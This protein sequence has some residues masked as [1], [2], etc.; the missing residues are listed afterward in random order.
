MLMGATDRG[1]CWL[2]FG[3]EP[4]P[5]CRQLQEAFPKA[6]LRPDDTRLTDW[7]NRVRDH[8]LLPEAALNLPLDI[9]GTAFQARVW[10]ALRQIPLGE[11]RSYSDLARTIGQPT[12]TRAVAAA[13]AANRVAVL[14]PCHRII[15]RDGA[16]TGYRWGVER[17]QRL[18]ENEK[19]NV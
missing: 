13:C 18:L 5:M 2:S 8:L 9:Q 17:K 19:L 11:T 12:A 15:G 3:A 7:F 4:E 16:M 14:I 1:I 10:R 6:S